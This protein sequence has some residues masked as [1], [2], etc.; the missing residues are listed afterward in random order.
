M[1]TKCEII[2]KAKFSNWIKT[3][4]IFAKSEIP[5]AEAL[6]QYKSLSVW[7]R[8]AIRKA[9]LYRD[10]IRES[11]TTEIMDTI[12]FEMSVLVDLNIIATEYDIDPL[13][14]AMCINPPCKINS[15]IFVK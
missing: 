3:S 1:K 8:I 12:A 10:A 7:K 15:K 6:R 2:D 13:V 5:S 11:P 9:M 14:V 4:N